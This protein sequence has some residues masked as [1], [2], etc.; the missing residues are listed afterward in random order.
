[1]ILNW[2]HWTHTS[3]FL[4]IAFDWIHSSIKFMYSSSLDNSHILRII[5]SLPISLADRFWESISPMTSNLWQNSHAWNIGN[6]GELNREYSTKLVNLFS[7]QWEIMNGLTR[8]Q[9]HA[10]ELLHSNNHRAPSQSPLYTISVAVDSWSSWIHMYSSMRNPF[11]ISPQCW[12]QSNNFCQPGVKIGDNWVV[13]D[14]RCFR[15]KFEK[16]KHNS[17]FFRCLSHFDVCAIWD[18]VHFI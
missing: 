2:I 9:C 5:R 12:K 16:K 11:P 3:D 8:T 10:P 17:K 6:T 4:P 14:N 15:F 13:C 7:R 1:M 18:Y